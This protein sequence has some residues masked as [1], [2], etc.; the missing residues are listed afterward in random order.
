M[1]VNIG[2][3]MQRWTSDTLVATKHCVRIPEAETRK[4]LTRQSFVFFGHPDD[5]YEVKCLDGSDKYE[6]ITGLGY[7][8]YR[9]S[10]TY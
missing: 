7:L 10:L 1:I 9:F 3:L 5:D 8:N 6:P 4:M 2:D